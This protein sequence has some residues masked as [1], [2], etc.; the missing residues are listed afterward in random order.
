[1]FFKASGSGFPDV[2]VDEIVPANEAAQ[3]F[4]PSLGRSFDIDGGPYEF[5]TILRDF[6]KGQASWRHGWPPDPS[7][8]TASA[9][10]GLPIPSLSAPP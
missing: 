8:P 2:T 1:M 9:A 3:S 6:R 10:S 4:A 7:C 5:Q